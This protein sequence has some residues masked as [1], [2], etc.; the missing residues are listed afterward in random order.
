MNK[1]WLL[2]ILLVMLLFTVG[3]QSYTASQGKDV[4]QLSASEGTL[5]VTKYSTIEAERQAILD[6]EMA[7]Q[8]LEEAQR[9]AEAEE[10]ERMLAARQAMEAEQQLKQSRQ[11]AWDEAQAN[12]ASLVEKNTLLERSNEDLQARLD[13]TLQALSAIEGEQ[14]STSEQL[15]IALQQL[16]ELTQAKTDL[17]ARLDAALKAL[18]ATK[19]E[20]TSTGE[21]LTFAL[22]ELEDMTQAYEN[23]TY[24]ANELEGLLTE[25]QVINGEL[26]DLLSRTEADFLARESAWQS[27]HATMVQTLESTIQA[28]GE[29]MDILKVQLEEKTSTLEEKIKLEQE[30]D[31]EAKRLAQLKQQELAQKEALERQLEE[32]ER[33]RQAALDQLYRQIPPLDELTFPRIYTTDKPT[34]LFTDQSQLHAMLLPLDDTPWSDKSMAVQV[35]NSISDLSY[36]VIFL[37]GH[38]QNVIDV[39]RQVGMHAVLVEGGAIITSLPIISSST[40]GASV[41]FS[42]KKTLRLALAY[43]PEYKVLATFADGGDWKAVQKSVTQARQESL[44]AIIAEGSVTEPTLLAASLFEPSHQDWNTFSPI[45]YRQVDYLWPLT[46]LLEDEQFYDVYRVTHFSSATD[47]GNTLVKKD[48]KE[49]IDY[50]F[51]RK[52][53]PL[54]SSML[55]IGGESVADTDGIARYGLVSSFLVP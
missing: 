42:E 17:Q 33:L 8:Q 12:I 43:L 23:L 38:M 22:Q 3:C 5:P 46:T 36:P 37:T 27:Q 15:V 25:Q 47:A 52:M 53:L 11:Q 49:R 26:E 45:A 20:A 41:Q 48:F 51:S 34:V 1:R 18:V 24:H 55:T 31:A 6:A 54:A 19:E 7:K 44:K 16:E 39:V 30:R 21:Q 32:E 13:A 50:M 28:L 14:G 29:E 9:K 35:K 10:Q 2:P 40:H 4:I